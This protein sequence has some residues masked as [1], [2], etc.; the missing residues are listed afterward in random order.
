MGLWQKI[1][2][3]GSKVVKGIKRGYEWVR[4]KAV[5]V[6]KKVWGVAKP[7]VTAINPAAGAAM[8]AAEG[9][10]SRIGGALGLG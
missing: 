9:V 5:P 2:D 6:V 10:A 7:V 4:D 3:F 8:N 1:K